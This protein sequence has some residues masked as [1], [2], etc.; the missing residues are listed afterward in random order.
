[1]KKLFALLMTLMMLCCAA[2]AEESVDFV[3]YWVMTGVEMAG[4][5]V[6]PPMFG[7]NAYMELYEDGTCLMVM[8]E[9][10]QY[11]TWAATGNGIETTDA[12]GVVDSFVM[13]D[14]ALICEQDGN[15][16]IFTQEVYVL[17]L[18]G[19]TAD[20]FEGEWIFARLEM[21]NAFFYPEEVGIGMTLSV[22]D[23]KGVLTMSDDSGAEDVFRGVCEIEEIPDAG[24]ALYF[25]Y[26]DENGRLTGEGMMLLKFEGEELV[27]FMDDGSGVTLCY[28]FDRAAE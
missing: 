3:G 26:Q 8:L 2:F 24:T 19:L 18:S 21:G 17:P 15:K 1:M 22:L 20:D 14:G 5:Q 28:C 11:G 13:T 10:A 4:M 12:D 23:G 27:W 16:M 9:E 7:L 6:D 25:L